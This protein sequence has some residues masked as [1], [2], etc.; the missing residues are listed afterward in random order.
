M[1]SKDLGD[2]NETLPEVEG[3]MPQRKKTDLHLKVDVFEAATHEISL[4]DLPLLQ[5][6]TV[7]VFWPHRDRDLELLI[8]LGQGYL[9]LD[10]IGRPLS[11]AMKFQ[12]GPDFAMLGMMITAPRLQTLGTGRWLLQ[13]IMGACGN[14][15]L[16][17]S[18][19]RAGYRLYETAGFQPV[20]TIRQQQGIAREIYLPEPVPDTEVRALEEADWA[21]LIEL[22][23][24]AYGV[25][26][27][28]VIQALKVKSEC[29]VAE[30]AGKIVGYAMIRNFGRGQVIGPVVADCD[31]LAMQLIAPLIQTR[32]GKF[33]RIDTPVEDGQLTAFLSAAG[34]GLFDTVTEMYKGKQRRATSGAVM[35]G[36]AAHSLG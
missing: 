26:R 24:G 4:T 21:T 16:R 2:K 10:E 29:I 18:A 3:A 5:E 36:L 20:A 31:E 35:Y 17:L 28:T 9:A 33:L 7:G 23:T 34:L 15:D 27:E 19:T 25:G 6:L 12:M 32:T 1:T 8:Q 14:R 22:D 13:Q 30:K 11:S